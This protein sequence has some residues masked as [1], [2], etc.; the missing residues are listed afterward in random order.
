MKQKYDKKAE[1]NGEPAQGIFCQQWPVAK[2]VL[3]AEQAIIKKWFIKW[4]IG[5]VIS[6]GDLLFNDL[7]CDNKG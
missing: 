5:L 4:V 2:M 3:L 1:V 6:A 7:G